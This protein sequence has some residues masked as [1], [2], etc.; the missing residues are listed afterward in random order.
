VAATRG[1]SIDCG[2]CDFVSNVAAFGGA[3]YTRD[4]VAAFRG[5]SFKSNNAGWAPGQAG[6]VHASGSGSLA[7][8]RSLVLGNTAGSLGGGIVCTDT[9]SCDATNTIFALNSAGSGAAVFL[10]QNAQ[11]TLKACTLTGNTG[12]AGLELGYS[13]GGTP[14]AAA[15]SCIFDDAVPLRA[16]FGTTLTVAA[17]LVTGGAAGCWSGARCSTVIGGPAALVQLSRMLP[18]GTRGPDTYW[19]PTAGSPGNRRGAA[20]GAGAVDFLG[21]PRVCTRAVGRGWGRRG[22]GRLGG[23]RGCAGA[24]PRAPFARAPT[25][26]GRAP[27]SPTLPLHKDRAGRHHGHGCGAVLLL[28]EFPGH[29]GR[30]WVTGARAGAPMRGRGAAR[31]RRAADGQGRGLRRG[32]WVAFDPCAWRLPPPPLHTIASH[33]GR[34]PPTPAPPPPP[35]PDACA[36]AWPTCRTLRAAL[37]AAGS[38]SYSAQATT[39]TFDPSIAA[40][41]LASDLPMPGA[42]GVGPLAPGASVTVS[43]ARPGGGRVRVAADAAA[44]AAAAP[45]VLTFVSPGAAA[46]FEDIDAYAVFFHATTSGGAP[47][48][49]RFTNCTLEAEPG[50]AY[51]NPGISTADAAVVLTRAVLRNLQTY[52]VASGTSPGRFARAGAV[53]LDPG[54]LTAT[55]ARGCGAAT[56]ARRGGLWG[57]EMRSGALPTIAA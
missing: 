6:A 1:S 45:P 3:V 17:S 26:S 32:V 31:K 49:L 30:R 53:A 55:G 9:T 37:A 56:G 39:I 41:E 57:R 24:G 21:N 5:C 52:D 13:P 42:P 2:R 44:A 14:A 28:P 10:H 29:P 16:I 23:R 18:P 15:S 22:T 46:A 8:D 51:P 4:S 7:L 34:P 36:A 19:S 20:A 50:R 35:P 48:T 11:A 38:D 12:T 54:T 47:S 43:G 33:R 27:L 25:L 40:V